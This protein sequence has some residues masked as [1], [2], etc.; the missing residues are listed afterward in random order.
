MEVR[1]NATD[2]TSREATEM[3]GFSYDAPHAQTV[4]LTGDFNAWN[5]TS[6]PM[7][8]QADGSWFLQ[9]HLSRGRHHYQFLVDGEP[10]LDPHA[11]YITLEDRHENVS[12][13]A[14]D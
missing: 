7:Q 9:L 8:R 10:V 13:I 3:V 6:D 1:M 11:M 2:K 12:F 5:R 14:L 4:Y